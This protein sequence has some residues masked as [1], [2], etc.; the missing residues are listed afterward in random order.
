MTTTPRE[1]VQ[2]IH[3]ARDA[4]I[5]AL[6]SIEQDQYG[7]AMILSAIAMLHLSHAA[8]E[9][10]VQRALRAVEHGRG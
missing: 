7:A 10:D 6:V 8:D 2:R 4:V 5:S 3:M 9:A 1:R